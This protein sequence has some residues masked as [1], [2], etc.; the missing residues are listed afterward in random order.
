M[1]GLEYCTEEV[2]TKQVF[3]GGVKISMTAMRVLWPYQ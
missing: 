3:E 2:C 1:E